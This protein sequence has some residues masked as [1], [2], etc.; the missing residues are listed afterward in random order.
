M[1]L[2]ADALAN[3]ELSVDDLETIAAGFS[4]EGWIKSEV[5]PVLSELQLNMGYRYH[6][7]LPSGGPGP[8]G[9]PYRV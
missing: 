1:N 8:K 2:S 6:P 5:N 4:F 9:G 3:R 7:P